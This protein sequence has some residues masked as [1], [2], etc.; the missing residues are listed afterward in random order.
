MIPEFDPASDLHA[1]LARLGATAD[2]LAADVPL[3]MTKH[4]AALWRRIRQHLQRTDVGRE[5]DE[6]V[7]E[8]LA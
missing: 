3:D 5:I 7:E 1:A 6:L 2:K 4:F 8:L